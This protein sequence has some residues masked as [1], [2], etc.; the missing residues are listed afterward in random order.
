M[1]TTVEIPDDLFRAS[2]ADAALHGESLKQFMADALNAYLTTRQNAA[3]LRRG[4]RSVFG[5]AR[6]AEIQEVDEIVAQEF[7]Q[8]D[9]EDWL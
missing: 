9:P 3:P 1:K 8:V 4:W 5:K 2:K 7:G 6:P